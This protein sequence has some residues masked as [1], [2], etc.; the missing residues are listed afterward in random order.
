[1]ANDGSRFWFQTNKDAPNERVVVVDV[2]ADELAFETVVAEDPDAVLESAK[3]VGGDFLL[4]SYSRDVKNELYLH[5]LADGGR[6]RRFLPDFIGT[7]GSIS[8]RRK[9]GRFFVSVGSYLDAGSVYEF[10]LVTT[11]PDAGD[12]ALVRETKMDLSA[13]EFVSEQ[14]FYA[15]KDGTRIPVRALL[16][17]S[18]PSSPTSPLTVVVSSVCR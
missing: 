15:S 1:M 10:D 11:A 16:R 9:Y 6:I 8:G 7:I 3:V 4:L 18:P 2:D 12:L 14:V 17:P 13:G 5:R